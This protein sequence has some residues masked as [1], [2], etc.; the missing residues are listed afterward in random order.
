MNEPYQEPGFDFQAADV[1]RDESGVD[2]GEKVILRGFTKN[3]YLV[4]D[5]R[6]PDGSYER[7]CQDPEWS[8]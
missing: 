8:G 6:Q 4:Y 3:R 1:I 5:V 7:R 2:S